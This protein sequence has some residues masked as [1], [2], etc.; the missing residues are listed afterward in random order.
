MAETKQLT[1]D[2]IKE[3]G[4][5]FFQKCEQ[6]TQKIE[7]QYWEKDGLTQVQAP[8]IINPFESSDTE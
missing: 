5:D 7:R 2:A 6:H 4:K 3:I 1:I 8:V